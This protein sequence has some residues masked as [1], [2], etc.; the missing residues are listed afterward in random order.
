MSPEA[1][2]RSAENAI[3]VP[4][5]DQAGSAPPAVVSGCSLPVP[6]FLTQISPPRSYAILPLRPG[7]AAWAAGA[8]ASVH[9]SRAAA[10]AL[11]P[12]VR[13]APP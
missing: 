13:S 5:G 10:T 9:S 2:S 8:A 7:K 11:P 1:P 4:S 6:S 12:E 3:L